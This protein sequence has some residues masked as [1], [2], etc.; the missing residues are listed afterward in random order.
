MELDDTSAEGGQIELADDEP[1]LLDGVVAEPM[2]PHRHRRKVSH[3]KDPVSFEVGATV[4]PLGVGF[5]LGVT[6]AKPYQTRATGQPTSPVGNGPRQFSGCGGSG[7]TY[8]A[9]RNF[10]RRRRRY[11]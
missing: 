6:L 7:S 5:L 9:L 8:N 3:D 11:P 10:Y 4:K 2:I 1:D